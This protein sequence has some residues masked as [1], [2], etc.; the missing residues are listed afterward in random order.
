MLLRVG[1]IRS[2]DTAV[3]T[4]LCFG[5]AVSLLALMALGITLPRFDLFVVGAVL[6]L[7][8]NV[9]IQLRRD[10]SHGTR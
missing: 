6:I 1:N 5:P 4:L 8:V 2:E 9:R 7:A 3:N 10:A